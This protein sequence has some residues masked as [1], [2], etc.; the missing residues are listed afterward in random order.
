M[1]TETMLSAESGTPNPA[2]AAATNPAGSAPQGAPSESGKPEGTE[3]AADKAGEQGGQKAD[4]KAEGEKGKAEGDKPKAETKAP[5]AYEFKMPEGVELDKAAADEFSSI[6]KE[7][8][9]TQDQA[10]RVAEVAMK[11]QQRQAEQQVATVRGWAE[12]CKTD[13]EFGGDN[14][15]QNLGVARQAIDTF[16]SKELKALLDKTGLGN[17]PELVRFAFKAGKAIDTA[18]YQPGGARTPTDQTDPAKKLYPD[19]N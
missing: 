7:L 9:L 4:E 10:Q 2:D 12:Q 18:K 6:A 19:M 3:Q 8:D 5:E 14:L 16:G 13:K 11:M 17:H 1:T 15:E